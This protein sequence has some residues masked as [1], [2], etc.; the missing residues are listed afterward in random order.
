MSQGIQK[1][2]RRYSFTTLS[3]AAKDVQGDFQA[4][5]V[6]SQKSSGR[7]RSRSPW[8]DRDCDSPA[9]RRTISRTSTEKSFRLP[10]GGWL[11]FA[12]FISN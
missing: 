1:K 12:G 3:E 6:P 10:A 5:Q 9:K 2:I 11:N 4:Q 8:V 7:K